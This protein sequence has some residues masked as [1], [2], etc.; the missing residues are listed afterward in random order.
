MNAVYRH[1]TNLY[2][3]RKRLVNRYRQTAR[4]EV[5]IQQWTQPS[6]IP[7]QQELMR[8]LGCSPK[9]LEETA[10]EYRN[11]PRAWKLLSGFQ[12]PSK[13]SDGFAKSLDIAE[14][15]VLW[16]LVK[17]LRPRV[18]VELGVQYGI[19]SRLWKEALKAYVPQHELV[20]CDL[21]DRR[22]FISDSEARFYHKD[23]RE[24][25]P[26]LFAS[27]DVG[28]LHNDA[29]PYDLIHWSVAEALSHK[30]PGLTFHDVGNGKRGPTK[31]ESHLLS[32]EEKIAQSENWAEYG[33]WER[34]VMAEVFDE[35][36]LKQDFAKSAKYSAGIFDSLFGLG[37]VLVEDEM[38]AEDKQNRNA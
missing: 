3:N 33:T 7:F 18:V 1:A 20:L 4:N 34:H 32:T 21:N 13:E 27:G 8:F 35:A 5:D 25:L 30:V 15:F 17:H 26:K 38:L 31:I 28:I 24:V 2:R 22:L 6:D 9:W 10:L 16:T 19:S 29:H 14:G 12:S 36:L 23:A 37:I 11:C